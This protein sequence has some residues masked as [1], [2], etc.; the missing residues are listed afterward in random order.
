MT[1]GLKSPEKKFLDEN[2]KGFKKKKKTF[3]MDMKIKRVS[4]KKRKNLDKENAGSS[5]D[6]GFDPLTELFRAGLAL[7]RTRIQ[8]MSCHVADGV[9]GLNKAGGTRARPANTLS[10]ED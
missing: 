7:G 4:R 9:E 8:Q 5:G 2:Q 1:K 3:L 10:P 6:S